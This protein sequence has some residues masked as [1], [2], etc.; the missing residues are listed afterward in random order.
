MRTVLLFYPSDSNPAAYH[1]STSTHGPLFTGLSHFTNTETPLAVVRKAF[2]STTV[3]TCKH[4][5]AVSSFGYTIPSFRPAF[6][7]IAK[8]RRQGAYSCDTMHPLCLFYECERDLGYSSL[9]LQLQLQ[10]G[11]APWPCTT[12]LS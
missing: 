10:L 1:T 7:S 8:W 2:V 9:Q 3:C 6:L 12:V 4:A 11:Q 5:P